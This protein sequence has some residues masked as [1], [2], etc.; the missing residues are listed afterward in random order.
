MQDGSSKKQCTHM[1]I[2]VN[3]KIKG[4]CCADFNS[5][6]IFEH[7]KKYIALNRE[8]INKRGRLKIV[9]TSCLG[10]CA[11]GPNLYITPDNIWYTFSNI[12]DIHE[13]IENQII[14]GIKVD[15][16]INK[17]ICDE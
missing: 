5:E 2:C 7:I 14:H 3:Q 12:K 16:L 15:K 11:V 4:K 6:N 9:K 1:F 13:I 10:Q 8:K 17:G